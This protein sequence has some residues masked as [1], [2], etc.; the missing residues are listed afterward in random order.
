M[1]K[2]FSNPLKELQLI[3]HNLKEVQRSFETLWI[4]SSAY[5]L[6]CMNT[7]HFHIKKNYIDYKNLKLTKKDIKKTVLSW[8]DKEIKHEKFD[9]NE[10]MEKIWKLI[11][12]LR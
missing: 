3:N 9:L 11:S 1:I 2:T 4:P 8:F 6:E 5:F 12:S 10:L 7:K